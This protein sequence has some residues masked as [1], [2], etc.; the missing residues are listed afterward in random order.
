MP[1]TNHGLEMSVVALH[2]K[3][4]RVEDHSQVAVSIEVVAS[5][6]RTSSKRLHRCRKAYED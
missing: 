4:K 6:S 5:S 2:R 1:H 3:V